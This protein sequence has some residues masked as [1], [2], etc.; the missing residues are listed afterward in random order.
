MTAYGDLAKPE[1]VAVGSQSHFSKVRPYL[2]ELRIKKGVTSF[3]DANL[4]RRAMP[5][6]YDEIIV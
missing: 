2:P 3:F 1:P 4:S 5:R 6:K